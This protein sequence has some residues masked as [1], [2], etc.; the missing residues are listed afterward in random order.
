MFEAANLWE[1]SSKLL[2]IFMGS[3]WGPRYRQKSFYSMLVEGDL[4]TCTEDNCIHG[5][6]VVIYAYWFLS[7]DNKSIFHIHD[8]Q[9]PQIQVP[10]WVW[11]RIPHF[12]LPL[13]IKISAEKGPTM[14]RRNGI[15]HNFKF[16]C[17]RIRVSSFWKYFNSFQS[18][19]YQL[20]DVYILKEHPLYSDHLDHVHDLRIF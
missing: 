15:F 8:S 20:Q 13:T 17:F 5:F 12:Q 14:R 3:N 4:L 9:T 7:Q 10:N 16:Q 1:T 6:I 2:H 18:V 11:G 19:F